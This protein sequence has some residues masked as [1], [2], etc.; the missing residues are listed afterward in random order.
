MQLS[1]SHRYIFIHV[2]RTGGTSITEALRPYAFVPGWSP[3]RLPV[4]RK[5]ATNYIGAVLDRN[6]G[7]VTARELQAALPRDVFDSFFKFAFVRNPWDWQVS[8]YCHVIQRPDNPNYAFYNESLPTFAD[9]L[10]WQIHR[11]GRDVQSELVLGDD[12]ELLVDFVGRFETLEQ[13]FTAVCRRIGV[14]CSLEHRNASTH[15]DYRDYYTPETKRLVAEAY[16]R[17][18]ELFGYSFDG[19]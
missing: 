19:R 6:W 12:G 4:I 1:Y 11:E 3:Y 15:R 7:H 10:D 9:Y 18:I 14:D 16:A 5:F 2:N 17:D 13:D 8:I